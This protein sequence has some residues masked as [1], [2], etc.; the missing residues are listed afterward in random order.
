MMV[1][2]IFLVSSTTKH[3]RQLSPTNTN[4]FFPNNIHIAMYRY[5]L[6]RMY[7]WI[8]IIVFYNRID[9]TQ[10]YWKCVSKTE[11]IWVGEHHIRLGMIKDEQHWIKKKPFRY[12]KCHFC[13]KYKILH[14]ETL[15]MHV[16]HSITL[17]ICP[18]P[19]CIDAY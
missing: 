18:I 12:I 5:I 16:F 13:L 14:G 9:A 10:L 19:K 2:L 4:F 11:Y 7:T 6:I 1:V 8:N 17:C 3:F 15:W